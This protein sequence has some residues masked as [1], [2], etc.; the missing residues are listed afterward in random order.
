[1]KYL[2][3]CDVTIDPPPQNTAAVPGIERD[4]AGRKCA[5]AVYGSTRLLQ[6]LL[7]PAIVVSTEATDRRRRYQACRLID[8]SAIWRQKGMT[9][10]DRLCREG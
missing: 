9:E 5:D 8:L 2:P 1:M 10:Q 7:V 3:A 6:S 4:K